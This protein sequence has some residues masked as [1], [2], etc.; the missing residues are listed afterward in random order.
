MVPFGRA[1]VVLSMKPRWSTRAQ[2][3]WWT[4]LLLQ[5]VVDGI[6]VDSC[7]V[8]LEGDVA[9]VVDSGSFLRR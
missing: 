5:A 2:V 6:V 3:A 4:T 8:S 9:A 7:A 1:A